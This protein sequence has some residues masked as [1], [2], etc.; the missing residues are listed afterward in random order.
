MYNQLYD[1]FVTILPRKQCDISKGFSVLNSLLPMTEKYRKSKDQGG[2]YGAVL[3]ACK[4]LLI[5]YIM[6]S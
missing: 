6:T 4:K 2:A 3:T 1:Y 5:A